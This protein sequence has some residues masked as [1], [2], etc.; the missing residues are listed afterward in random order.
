MSNLPET[1]TNERLTNKELN[2]LWNRYMWFY[3]GSCSFPLY[4]GMGYVYGLLPLFKKYYKNKGDI[5]KGLNRHVQMF[6][7]EMQVGSIIYGIVVGM[8]EQKALGKDIDDEVI[9]TTKV[10]LMGPVAG[11]GDSMLVGMIIPI[12]LSIG[13]SLGEGGNPLGPLFYMI[14]YPLLIILGSHFLFFKGYHLGI[15]A[16]KNL[17]G[18]QANKIREAVMLLGTIVMGGL[19]ASY[20]KFNTI[21]SFVKGTETVT[22][23][24]ILDGIFPKL[25]PLA[26][27][28]CVWYFMSKKKVSAI[29]MMLILTVFIFLCAFGGII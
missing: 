21:L 29:K 13:I 18:E 3:D 15:N 14:T 25:V 7:T 8:E 17:I 5:S 6:N 20:I 28:L 27:V 23:Q 22:V 2:S 9:R 16:V 19:S 26:I 4:H 24:S 12:L 1:K 10:G 11:I